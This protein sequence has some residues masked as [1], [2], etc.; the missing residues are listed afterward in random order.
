MA[1]S[2]IA[3][4]YFCRGFQIQKNDPKK[5]SALVIT[6]YHKNFPFDKSQSLNHRNNPYIKVLKS[7]LFLNSNPT[8]QPIQNCPI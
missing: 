2:A 4:Q 8:C 1:Y 7:N 3:G 6:D 5:G